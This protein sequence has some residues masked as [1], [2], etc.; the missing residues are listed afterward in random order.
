MI[1]AA[2]RVNETVRLRRLFLDYLRP[3]FPI[4]CSL[5]LLWLLTGCASQFLLNPDGARKALHDQPVRAEYPQQSIEV[6]NQTGRKLKG[7][8]FS[9]TGDKG[10]VLVGGGNSMGLEQTAHYASFLL[11]KG[12]RVLVY[13][14]QGYDDNEGPASI[15][16]LVP[17]AMAFYTYAKQTF[18]DEKVLLFGASISAATTACLARNLSPPPPIVIEAII[19]P[20]TIIY[21]IAQKNWPLFLIGFPIAWGAAM[22]VPDSIEPAKCIAAIGS[23]SNPPPILFVYN[24]N[25]KLAPYSTIKSLID[26]YKGPKSTKV[27]SC[28]L[29][30]G[31]HMNLYCDKSSREIVISFI[32]DAFL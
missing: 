29:S 17:D 16:S 25:D 5:L 22:G 15:D 32:Q 1:H 6:T 14:Y 26:M 2:I 19:D 20:K 7:I 10:I 30:N 24:E 23:S 18:S 4:F 27:S 12:F 3:L 8:V 21:S 11:N 31:C 13:S 9:K 28:N